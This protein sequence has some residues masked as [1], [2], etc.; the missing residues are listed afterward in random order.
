MSLLKELSS[1]A[2]SSPDLP[3][4][5]SA[6]FNLTYGETY[7]AVCK[8]AQALVKRGV[9]PGDRVVVILP[10]SVHFCVL[11]YAIFHAGATAV[12]VNPRWTAHEIEGAIQLVRPRLVI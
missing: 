7:E 5:L 12:L 9:G 10:N 8:V 2:K 3:F 4:L 11:T 6:D 1:R